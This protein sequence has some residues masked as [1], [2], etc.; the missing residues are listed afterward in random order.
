MAYATY[1]FMDNE[2]VG[3][4]HDGR[5]R[6]VATDPQGSVVHLMTSFFV[7]SDTL[8]YWPYG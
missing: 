4:Q 2:L 5:Q 6:D 7:S 8:S 3:L 1:T